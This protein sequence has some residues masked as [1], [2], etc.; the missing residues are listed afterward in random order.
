[1]G[2]AKGWT[3]DVSATG[4]FFTT[5]QDV[6]VVA[7]PIAFVLELDHADPKDILQVA[8]SGMILRVERSSDGIGVAVRITS[9]D[10]TSESAGRNGAFVRWE[11]ERLGS[12][13]RLTHASGGTC[14]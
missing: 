1:M 4:L 9:Y 3:R 2:D 6:L 12:T 10:F 13:I 5:S 8:C 11:N 7:A 14:P